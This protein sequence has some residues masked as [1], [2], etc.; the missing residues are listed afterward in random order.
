MRDLRGFLEGAWRLRR[1][2]EDRRGGRCGRF[3][4]AA[5]FAPAGGELVYR[6]RGVLRLGRYQG[7]AGRV[8]R[9]RFPAPG[10]AD[11]AFEDGAAFHA[12]DLGDGRCVVEHR[13]RDDIYRGRFHV[14]G[15]D[16]WQ[17]VWLVAG[18]R[19]DQILTAGYQRVA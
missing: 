12:L 7:R 11:V 18:P 15:P 17:V 4:G 1:R 14:A 19:K 2:L 9:Y 16:A 13:C 10:R 6:E 3:D 8:Y 5:V